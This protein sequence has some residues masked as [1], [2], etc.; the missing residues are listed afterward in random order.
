VHRRASSKGIEGGEFNDNQQGGGRVH[1]PRQALSLSLS[2]SLLSSSLSRALSLS[3][4]LLARFSL[5]L[6][7]SRARAL[8][9]VFA[10]TVSHAKAPLWPTFP[11][12][13]LLAP[14]YLHTDKILLLLRSHYASAP[15]PSGHTTRYGVSVLRKRAPPLSPL[16]SP[17]RPP[18]HVTL[19]IHLVHVVCL[20]S[21]ISLV[22]HGP[23][24]VSANTVSERLFV[25]VFQPKYEGLTESPPSPASV[26][27]SPS[28][29]LPPPPFP[30]PR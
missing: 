18:P 12:K 19:T 24:T 27:P 23:C 11:A 26:L 29:R 6:S 14:F 13:G 28:S 8:S 7:L 21:L 9:L 15:P 22:S 20:L 4:P 17:F 5:S 1:R 10:Q 2:L 16:A 3:S 30:T 25:L